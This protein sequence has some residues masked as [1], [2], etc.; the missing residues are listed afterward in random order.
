MSARALPLLFVPAALA[1]GYAVPERHLLVFALAVLAIVPLAAL[2]GRAT[3]ALA[4]AIGGG[5]GGLLNATFGN[6]AELIIGLFAL[7]AGLHSLVKASLTGSIISNLLLVLGASALAGGLTR[8]AQ[9][10]NRTAA[11]VGTTMLL[12]SATGLAVPAVFHH[13]AP[14]A[15][16]PEHGLD[17]S[18]AVVLLLTYAASLVFMLVTHRDLYAGN[19]P[20]HRNGG[21]SKDTW[22]MGR[23]AGRV[24]S[25]GGG[26][27]RAAGRNR[28]GDR[29]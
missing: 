17:A 9:Q 19:G 21:L 15:T 20:A 5:L 26:G 3:S 1:A 2:I 6:A 8:R 10:F 16:G 4:D 7:R 24:D 29:A 27:E 11:G 14:A 23:H 13:V 22:Q 28:R 25:G 12:L 18:I